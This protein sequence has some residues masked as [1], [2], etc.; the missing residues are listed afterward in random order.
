[1]NQ[2]ISLLNYH[3]HATEMIHLNIR[4]GIFT[5]HSNVQLQQFYKYYF[6]SPSVLLR[7]LQYM[8]VLTAEIS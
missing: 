7:T 5:V 3:M 6:P 1:M 2:T 4:K 8:K